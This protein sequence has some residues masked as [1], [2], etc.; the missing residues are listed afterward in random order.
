MREWLG[1][2]RARTADGKSFDAVE[3]LGLGNVRADVSRVARLRAADGER[4]TD[5]DARSV[6]ALKFNRLLDESLTELA[7]S[8]AKLCD[9]N[10]RSGVGDGA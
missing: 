1:A 2:D 6:N 9:V 7:G 10:V 4:A 8:V 5:A 3:G